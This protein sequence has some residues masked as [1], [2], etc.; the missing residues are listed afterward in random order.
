MIEF[1]LVGIPMIF[2]LISIFLLSITL[3]CADSCRTIF[4]DSQ[5]PA[6]LPQVPWLLK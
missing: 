3:G 5:S 4:Q 2:L 1:T 6:L